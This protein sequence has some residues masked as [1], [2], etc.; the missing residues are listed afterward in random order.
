VPT[1][2][3]KAVAVNTAPADI[4]SSWE[5]I[6]GLT[7][8]IYDIVRKVVIPANTSVRMVVCFGSKPKSFCNV[9]MN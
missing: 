3:A 5:N 4:P 1:I 8:R 2:A 7:A 6:A 9:F